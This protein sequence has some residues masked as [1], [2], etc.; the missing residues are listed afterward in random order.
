M[1]CFLEFGVIASA[2]A[3]CCWKYICCCH[4]TTATS[5][6]VYPAYGL[7]PA[8]APAPG[9]SG[10]PA[11]RDN[12]RAHGLGGPAGCCAGAQQRRRVKACTCQ[13]SGI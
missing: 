12:L 10:G 7:P 8:A 2:A 9:R 13:H 3:T 6:A 4:A 1:C 11:V 5:S